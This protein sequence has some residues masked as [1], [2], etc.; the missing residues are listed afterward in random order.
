MLRDSARFTLK[1]FLTGMIALRVGI[2]NP[3]NNAC[4][5]ALISGNGVGL[6]PELNNKLYI[7]HMQGIEHINPESKEGITKH[8]DYVKIIP[9]NPSLVSPTSLIIPISYVLVS[10]EIISKE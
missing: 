2:T 6:G 3:M 1:A 8:T 4:K 5:V 10:T 9:T 7:N